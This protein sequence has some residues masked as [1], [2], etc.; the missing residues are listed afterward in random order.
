MKSYPTPSAGT[1]CE[2]VRSKPRANHGHLCVADLATNPPD[3]L[4]ISEAAVRKQVERGT[5]RKVGRR[6]KQNLVAPSDGLDWAR[7]K[8][9]LIDDLSAS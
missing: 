2:A 5:L 1:A 8:L 9:G 4:G 6:G 7:R 3:R